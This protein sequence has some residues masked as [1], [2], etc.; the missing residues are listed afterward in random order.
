MIQKPL[1]FTYFVGIL[2]EGNSTIHEKIKKTPRQEF[3]LI[4]EFLLFFIYNR[5]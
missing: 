4:M 2:P 1:A 5:Q 3:P